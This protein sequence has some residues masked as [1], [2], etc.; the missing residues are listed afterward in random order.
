MQGMSRDTNFGTFLDRRTF[1]SDFGKG[2]LGIAVFGGAALRELPASAANASDAVRYARAN[3][4]FVNAYVI[5]R[6]KEAMIVDT[7]TA[8]N[9]AEI[10]KALRS[11][12]MRWSN[13][14]HVVLTHRHPDHVGSLPA[15]MRK[16]T[17][18]RAYTGAADLA[19]IRSPRKLRAVNDGDEV[20]GTMVIATPGHTPGHIA[21][22]EPSKGLLLTGDAAGT[23]SG[24]A[25]GPNERFSSDMA[26]ARKSL[27]ILAQ[28]NFEIML[29]GHGD[30]LTQGA[31]ASLASLVT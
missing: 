23:N 13:V 30:P 29:P 3:L 5:A 2:V 18:A 27:A 24:A 9:E 4:G 7:G 22:L 31:K 1:L 25:V 11:L 19:N 10:E 28:Q 8:G 15:V 26:Q 17:S 14:R 6:G 21:V 20:F 12:S 16:A